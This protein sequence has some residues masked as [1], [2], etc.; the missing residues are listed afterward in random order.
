MFDTHAHVHDAAFDPDRDAMLARARAAGVRRIMAVATDVTDSVRA[1]DVARSYELDYAIGVHPHEAKDA[2]GDLA[3][4]LDAIVADAHEPPRAVG[5]MGLDYYYDH[6][7]R[8]VQRRVLVAQLGYARERELP[9]IFHE[10]NAF[11]DFID[12]VRREAGTLRGVVHCFTGDAEQA[13][14]LT[15]EYGF[16]LGIGGVLTFKNAQPLRDAVVA[17]GLD[18]LVLETDAPYLAPVPERGRRNEPAFMAATAARLAELLGLSV[19]EVVRRT[20]A[21]ACAL[22]GP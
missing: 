9:A 21:A 5:E 1:C 16:L 19:D 2:P 7:P 10:R 11:E 13:R 18:H 15:G 3:A 4:A 6:S 12:T 22:F 17:V 14:R 8:D 20:T